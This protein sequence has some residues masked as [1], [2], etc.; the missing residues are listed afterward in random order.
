[1]SAA[2]VRLDDDQTRAI[3]A[4]AA[5]VSAGAGSGKTSVLTQRYARLVAEDHVPVDQILALTFTRKAAGEMYERIHAELR[6]RDTPFVR[7]QLARFEQSAISTLDSF[8]AA[9]VRDGCTAYGIPPTFAIDEDAVADAAE[10]KALAFLLEHAETPAI[11]HLIR[12]NGFQRAWKDGFA[13]LARNWFTVADDHDHRDGLEAQRRF[14]EEERSGLIARIRSLASQICDLDGNGPSCIAKAIER[15]APVAGA[16][17][18][19]HL[20]LEGLATVSLRCGSSK[21]PDVALLKELVTEVKERLKWFFVANVTLEN[22]SLHEQTIALADQFRVL[23]ARERRMSGIL[24][25]RDI[26]SLALRILTEQTAIRAHYRDRFNAIMIDEFQ[27]NN[28]EQKSL[29]YLLSAR[30]DSSGSGIPEPEEISRGKLFFVGDEKQSIYRF[31]GA[32]VSVFRTLSRELGEAAESLALGANYRSEPGL[33]QFFNS[34]F[35]GVFADATQEFEA[36][37]EPLRS[38]SATPGVVPRVELWRVEKREQADASFLADPDAE[39]YHL[40]REIR[41]LVQSGELMV[42]AADGSARPAGYADITILMRSTGNQIRL[43]RMLRLHGVPYVS[44]TAR[45]LFLEAPVNDMYQIL[46]L[47]LYPNDRAAYAGYLRSPLVG[48]SDEGIVR[49][50]LEDRPLFDPS[51]EL[52]PEDLARLEIARERHDQLAAFADSRPIAE[53]LQ[54]IWYEWGYRYHLLRRSEYL[55]YL[56]YYDLFRELALQFEGRG[57][58]AFLDEVRNHLGQNEKLN[59]LEIIRRDEDSVTIMTIHK[60]K[61]LEFP[62]VFLA[63]GSGKGRAA[64]ASNAPYHLS[65]RHGLAF[66]TGV[67]APG[68]VRESAANYLYQHE[69][70]LEQA[71]DEAE[72]KRL[73]YVAATRAECHLF[74]SGTADPPERSPLVLA[75]PAF[76]R[77]LAEIPPDS[78][79][80]LPHP[81]IALR[82]FS[83]VPVS[84]AFAGT[85]AGRRTDIRALAQSYERAEVVERVVPSLEVAVT[86]L[87]RR[88]AEEGGLREEGAEIA[89]APPHAI[90]ALLDDER[91]Q[92]MRLGAALGSYCH[93]LIEASGTG[94]DADDPPAALVPDLPERSRALFLAAGKEFAQT[95]LSS[96]LYATLRSE[97]SDTRLE[98]ELP[99]TMAIEAVPAPAR[100]VAGESLLVRGVIDLLATGGQGCRVVDFKSDRE[101][102][103][104]QYAVQLAIYREAA[105]RLSHGGTPGDGQVEALIFHLRTGR[106]FLFDSSPDGSILGVHEQRH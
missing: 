2:S 74:L 59:E 98:Y 34:F 47:V 60:S 30:P 71:Q 31:R 73:L 22:W 13:S 104:S 28:E 62:V 91:Y 50:L 42:R 7:E 53:L 4:S 40:A 17:N 105:R 61:G 15:A 19:E 72:L 85:G 11:S 68:A 49:Q 45:S 6:S 100:Q 57:L 41:S 5:V 99:F 9:I 20:L 88:V 26:T 86:E 25:Y 37:F 106:L 29:L 64:S 84:E 87:N 103:P 23:I 79:S 63:Y 43:E 96:P 56:E 3:R 46:Q 66:N 89:L 55:T 32:D 83:P 94:R 93:Y 51:H 54:V 1:M 80:G 92:E 18:P 82:E 65:K 52:V 48:L 14:V 76:A 81:Q 10:Q 102:D 27:D 75:D 8:S 101:L 12:L 97:G 70:E 16:E 69:S 24:S 44:Q 33:I 95:F 39:A 36:R 38:R 77:A 58:A 78:D 35:A 67:I 90:D 21:H